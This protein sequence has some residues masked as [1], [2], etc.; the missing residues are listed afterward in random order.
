MRK[1]SEELTNCMVI[2]VKIPI[3]NVVVCI[4]PAACDVWN[5]RAITIVFIGSLLLWGHV[6]LEDICTKSEQTLIH[7]PRN[8]PGLGPNS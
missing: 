3:H 4:G 8:H 1:R 5:M 2:V 6:S 7:K